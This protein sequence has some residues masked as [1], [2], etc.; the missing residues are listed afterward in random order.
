MSTN[1]DFTKFFP[2]HDLLIEIGRIEM[3]MENLKVRA[4][5]ERATL[6]PRLESRMVR[7]RTALKGLPA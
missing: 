3:A 1:V 5:D 6:Q 4:D 2:H 7:L